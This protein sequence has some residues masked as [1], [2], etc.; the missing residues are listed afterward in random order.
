[1]SIANTGLAPSIINIIQDRTLE[2]VFHDALYPNMLYRSE[3]TPEEW[4]ANIGQIMVFTKTGLIAPDTTPLQ[5][6]VDPSPG[7]YATESW[8]AEASQYGKTLDTHMPTSYVTLAPTILRDT[9]QLGL[10]SAQTMNRLVRDRLFRAYLG[11]TANLVAAAAI[12]ATVIRVSTL[13]GFTENLV[14]GRAQPVSGLNPLAVTFPGTAEPANTVVGFSP[15][16]PLLPFG[17]GTLQLGAALTAGLAARAV[18]AAFNRSVVYR[19]GGAVSIDGL[20]GGNVLTLQDIINVVARMRA[21]NIPPTSDGFYHIHVTPEGESQL[22]AD[23]QFQRIWQ[24][25]PDSAPMQ[26]AGIGQ[27]MGCRF[28]R[29]TE[30]PNSVNTGTLVSS[31]AGSSLCAPT[32]GADVVNNAGLAVQRA[33]V[34]GGTAIYEK[35]IDESKF[36]TEAGVTGKIGEFTVTNGGVMVMNRRIRYIMRAPLDRLQQIISQSWS[37][38]GDFPIPTDA[39]TG[40][41]A[42][43]KRAMVIEHA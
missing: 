6:G 32:I 40:N 11:G 41:A 42:R 5:P 33:I 29:N 7:S 2:R 14:N 10:Q 8:Q 15:D 30:N 26:Y 24:S 34:L 16:N 31:G 37:W 35:F 39:L 43:Y 9:K 4:V 22:F 12:G 18:V 28:Y 23:N 19:V 3:A 17:P 1:M 38:S 13:N 21:Q 25:L 36:M 20:V 27:L